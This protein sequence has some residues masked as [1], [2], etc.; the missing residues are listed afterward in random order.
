MTRLIKQLRDRAE[1]RG[2]DPLLEEAAATLEAAQMGLRYALRVWTPADETE[3]RE[4]DIIE[5]VEHL[6]G[7]A[8]EEEGKCTT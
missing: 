5:L 3:W 1:E 7:Y 4:T 2:V 8:L 6:L